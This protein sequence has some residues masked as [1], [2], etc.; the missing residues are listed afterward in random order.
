RVDRTLRQPTLTHLAQAGSNVVVYQPPH[1]AKLA[2]RVEVADQRHPRVNI[3][4]VS[5]LLVKRLRGRKQRD[6]NADESD[7]QPAPRR[8]DA[9]VSPSR[10]IFRRRALARK[11]VV[12]HVQ[13][14]RREDVH[15]AQKGRV[16]LISRFTYRRG[17]SDHLRPDGLAVHLPRTELV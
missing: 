9:N 8:A 17:R 15:L 3:S 1:P 4:T 12:A 7:F 6:V 10:R 13:S 11:E 16:D 2:H 5:V 14:L